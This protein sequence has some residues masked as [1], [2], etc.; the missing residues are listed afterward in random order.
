MHRE[1][2][3]RFIRATSDVGFKRM[4]SDPDT[5]ETLI[6]ELLGHVGVAPVTIATNQERLEIPLRGYNSFASMDYHAISE[7]REHIIVDMQV[8]HHTNFDKRVLFYA[9]STFANQEFEGGQWAPQIKDV[10]AIQFVDYST[11]GDSA[12]KYY[13]MINKFS[14]KAGQNGQLLPYETVKGIH[15]IQVE[16]KGKGIGELK[17]PVERKLS[18]LEWW[19]YIIKYSDRFDGGEIGRCRDLGMP[20]R[21]EQVLRQLEY[22]GLDPKKR[23]EYVKEE[24]EV[25]GYGD[26]LKRVEL[27]GQLQGIMQGIMRNFAK[28]REI[29]DDEIEGIEK[30]SLDESFVREV[31]KQMSM[32]N[33]PN[34]K[35]VNDLILFLRDKGLMENE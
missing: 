10:Y 5:A 30:N 34:A 16:L 22:I 7:R 25:D 13:E 12:L 8:I 27:R 24:E 3:T 21:M 4:L 11:N 35:N 9:A 26:E 14:L 23:E 18:D 1:S 6:N 32:S 31:W 15:L 20:M 29:G 17:F 28:D 2:N 19:Y 33:V